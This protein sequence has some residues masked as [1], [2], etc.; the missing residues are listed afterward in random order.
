MCSSASTGGA[1]SP[2]APCLNLVQMDRHGRAEVQHDSRTAA[3]PFC[4][5]CTLPPLAI[6]CPSLPPAPRSRVYVVNSPIASRLSLV[7][8]IWLLWFGLNSPCVAF[9]S[10]NFHPS[11]PYLFT[12][13]SL[14]FAV[15]CF[16]SLPPFSFAVPSC[17]EPLPHHAAVKAEAL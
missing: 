13:C 9:K 17:P 1:M 12:L 2:A 11:V 15:L 14:C 4:C 8:I 7:C 3:I 16:Q 10:I 5:I 6:A